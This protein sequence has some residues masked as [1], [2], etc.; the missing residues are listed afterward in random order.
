[1]PT[2]K[3]LSLNTY[4]YRRGGADV[5]FLEHDAL[6][7]AL[8][9]ATAVLCM[10]HPRNEPSQWS[11]YFIK[12][13]EF[14]GG[15]GTLQKLV[16]AAKV[17]YSWEAEKKLDR[18]LS[19]FRP[20]IAHAH[21]VYHHLSPSVLHSLR[22]RG[23]PTVMTAH[24]LKLACPAYKMVNDTGICERC[25]GGNLFHVVRH[26]CIHGSMAASMLVATE[27]AV[28]R[29]LGLYRKNL[30]RVITPSRFYREKLIEWGWPAKKLTHIPNFVELEAYQPQFQPG[31]Y[32]LY[33]GRLAAEKG[34]ATLISAAAR[35]GT[36]IRIAGTGPE[37][38]RLRDLAAQLKAPVEFLGHQ[39]GHPL[40]ELLRQAR[41]I[42]LPS[43]WYENAPMSILEAYA[44]G[45]PVIGARIGGI[46][47]MVLDKVTGLLF[48]SGDADQLASN[49]AHIREM[50]DE[51]VAEMGS[52]AH[53]HAANT[54]TKRRYANEI[55]DL[56]RS[57]G[58]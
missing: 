10:R 27:S 46:P 26:R 45:K 56:Y 5:L 29:A 35:A 13:L 58:V 32:F 18:L 30:D 22:R 38:A 44:S 9:W 24:D 48:A 37:E 34:V 31:D 55:L 57:L 47:E 33:F 8:G 17:V 28:H 20:D 3:L 15:Y 12:E 49:L 2:H 11:D 41:A 16:M 43:E 6:F 1:M 39:S 36:Q 21:C 42:V 54:F 4:H 53:A 40:R 23:V 50:P 51:R 7:R 19:R 14:G 25:R 52:Q